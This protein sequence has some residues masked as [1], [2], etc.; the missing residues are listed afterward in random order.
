[1]QEGNPEWP[2]APSTGRGRGRCVGGGAG[3]DGG[4]E[5]LR[6]QKHSQLRNNLQNP[7]R[8]RTTNLSDFGNLVY[9]CQYLTLRGTYKWL[10]VRVGE[11]E[12][13]VQTRARA[14]QVARSDAVERVS[15][16]DQ[17]VL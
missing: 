2:D 1:M 8:H 12:N 11:R 4:G 10:E 9:R 5:E 16:S 15:R 17:L 13:A 7:E 3:R 14:Q 6:K